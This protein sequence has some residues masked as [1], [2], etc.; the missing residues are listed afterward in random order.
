MIARRLLLWETSHKT[1][2]VHKEPPNT[3][4]KIELS[5][6][7]RRTSNEIKNDKKDFIRICPNQ[8]MYAYGLCGKCSRKR[9]EWNFAVYNTCI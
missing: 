7:E 1:H 2:K 9:S 3:F 4:D 5:K 8:Y 6:R